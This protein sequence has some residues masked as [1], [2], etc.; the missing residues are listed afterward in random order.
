MRRFTELFIW[1]AVLALLALFVG[2]TLY[3]FLF[4]E[5]RPHVESGGWS[6]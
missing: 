1:V 4:P 5:D 3:S 6:K 2:G